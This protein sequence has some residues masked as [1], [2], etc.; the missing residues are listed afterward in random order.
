MRS[1]DQAHFETFFDCPASSSGLTT[2]SQ[3]NQIQ[4]NTNNYS[5]ID[6]TVNKKIIQLKSITN[7]HSIA[8]LT[9]VKLIYICKTLIEETTFPKGIL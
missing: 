8:Q 4:I 6:D 7:E 9:V 2:I 5:I 1:M 3:M